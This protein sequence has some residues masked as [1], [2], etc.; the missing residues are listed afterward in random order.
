[1]ES[2][3][4]THN[5]PIAGAGLRHGMIMDVTNNA[6]ERSYTAIFWEVGIE[7]LKQTMHPDDGN[8]HILWPEWV[9]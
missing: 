3:D 7:P 4:T 5:P 9:L 1:M 6:R 2:G 8:R